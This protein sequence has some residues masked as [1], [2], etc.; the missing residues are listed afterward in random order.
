MKLILLEN[1]PNSRTIKTYLKLFPRV[2]DIEVHTYDDFKEVR[3]KKA[4]ELN[5]A[6]A[7]P[8]LYDTTNN[9]VLKNVQ[10]ILLRLHNYIDDPLFKLSEKGKYLILRTIYDY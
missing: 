1:D 7:V 10:S 4:H 2:E 6:L 5:P 8:V 9:I 3:K